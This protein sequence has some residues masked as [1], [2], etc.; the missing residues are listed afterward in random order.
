MQS[1][2]TDP[3]ARERELNSLSTVTLVVVM[4]IVTMTF[5]AM[6]GVFLYR[7]GDP[8]FW[9]HL[10]VPYILWLTTALLLASSFTVERARDRLAGG[11]QAAF[12]RIMRLTTGLALLFL[13]GQVAGWFQLLGS[14]VK[15]ANNPH[16]WF[17]FLF[18]GLH[19]IHILIGLVGL[20]Y[21][22]FRTR[23]PV[24]GPRFQMYTRVVARGVAIYWH[25][26]DFLWVLMFTLLLFWKQ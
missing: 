4:A 3:V 22:L 15:L 23:E 21:L 26:L 24:S 2:V 1:V 18:T 6:I 25:Y 14:G 17:L 7:S 19:G 16:S 10:N 5:S 8:K 20:G 9:G 11:D 12:N 13:A